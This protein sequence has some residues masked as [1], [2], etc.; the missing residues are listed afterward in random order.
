MSESILNANV[1]SSRDRSID[2]S[3]NRSRMGGVTVDGER[4]H[5]ALNSRFARFYMYIRMYINNRDPFSGSAHGALRGIPSLSDPDSLFNKTRNV[6]IPVCWI[7]YSEFSNSLRLHGHVP[8]AARQRRDSL[9][10]FTM[11]NSF[12]RGTFLQRLLRIARSR[13]RGMNTQWWVRC[14]GFKLISCLG[15][16]F[17]WSDSFYTSN[18]FFLDT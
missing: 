3:R 14:G 13:A 16:R 1:A 18:I 12:L 17:D 9:L 10:T 4:V 11:D 8:L 15:W 2:R 6:N 7:S 5:R